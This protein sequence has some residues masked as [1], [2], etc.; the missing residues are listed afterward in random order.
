MI[1]FGM[2]SDKS[3]NRR[4]LLDYFILLLSILLM[5]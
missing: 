1:Y 5:R 4:R 2:C 3:L